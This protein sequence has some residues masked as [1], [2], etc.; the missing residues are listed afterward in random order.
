MNII[1]IKLNTH[2]GNLNSE[3]EWKNPVRPFKGNV[4]SALP[5]NEI[6]KSLLLDLTRRV[7]DIVCELLANIKQR[8]NVFKS[9]FT[10]R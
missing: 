5:E 2:Y 3:W 7:G 10:L 4:A 9:A 8:K 1:Q 6:L